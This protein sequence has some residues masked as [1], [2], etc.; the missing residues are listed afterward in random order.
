MFVVN[1][2]VTTGESSA[3][4][5]FSFKQ[6]SNNFEESLKKSPLHLKF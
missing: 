5:N 1:N 4:V 6:N 3:D 2:A